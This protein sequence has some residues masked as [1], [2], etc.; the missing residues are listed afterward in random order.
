MT[1]VRQAGQRGGTTL[2]ADGLKIASA[3]NP[4]FIT[5]PS[6]EFLGDKATAFVRAKTFNTSDRTP[7]V[8]VACGSTELATFETSAN[9]Q[10]F[11]KEFSTTGFTNNT[12]TFSAKAV[13][14]VVIDSV[15]IVSY[16]EIESP[17]PLDNYP[18]IEITN[19][20]FVGDLE[21]EHTYY[22]TYFTVQPQGGSNTHIYGPF[23]VFTTLVPIRQVSA[24]N[25]VWGKEDNYICC[26]RKKAMK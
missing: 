15:K 12:I 8:T 11:S 21:E 6:I 14:R 20:H 13:K 10:M 2:Q 24:S 18:K 23:T 17:V 3:S 26:K 19:S 5:T 22:F 25:I 9:Y 1:S 4:G 16:V 7:A